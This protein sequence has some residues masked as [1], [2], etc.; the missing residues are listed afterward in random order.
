MIKYDDNRSYVAKGN[1]GYTCGFG[2][3]WDGGEVRSLLTKGIVRITM[4]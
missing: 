3:R 2:V 4:L 1:D